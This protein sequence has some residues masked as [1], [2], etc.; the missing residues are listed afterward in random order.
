M[1]PLVGTLN[2]NEDPKHVLSDHYDSTIPTYSV[3]PDTD[4]H[5]IINTLGARVAICSGVHAWTRVQ[6]PSL[7]QAVRE[8]LDFLV[9]NARKML[10]FFSNSLVCLVNACSAQTYGDSH[11]LLL[12][13]LAKKYNAVI[14]RHMFSPVGPHYL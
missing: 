11:T 2:T 14:L 6:T 13:S 1:V 10:D 5:N 12:L 9:Y 8:T 7:N 3:R 4:T